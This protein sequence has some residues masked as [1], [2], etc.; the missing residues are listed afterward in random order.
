M[1][2]SLN[3]CNVRTDGPTSWHTELLAAANNHPP[4]SV[5]VQKKL[6]YYYSSAYWGRRRSFIMVEKHNW[7]ADTWGT[8][9]GGWPLHYSSML[10]WSSSSSRTASGLNTS[11]PP[12]LVGRE[13]SASPYTSTL[14][15]SAHLGCLNAPECRLLYLS[16]QETII[17][18]HTSCIT[19]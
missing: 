10:V 6:N 17:H 7:P 16:L 9:I 2:V 8:L 4:I 1:C 5:L 15:F 14:H 3:F 18:N 13:F 11:T 19:H 12:L